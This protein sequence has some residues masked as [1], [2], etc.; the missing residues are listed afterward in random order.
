M[1]RASRAKPD[2]QPVTA[3]TLAQLERAVGGT[4]TKGDNTV[5]IVLKT[6]H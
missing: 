1:K 4:S 5:A 3:L 6:R 2:V